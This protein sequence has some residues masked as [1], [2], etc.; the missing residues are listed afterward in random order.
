MF[1]YYFE[2]AD[3]VTHSD[4]KSNFQT[5]RVSKQVQSVVIAQAKDAFFAIKVSLAVLRHTEKV[6]VL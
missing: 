6:L 1:K 4:L 2:N 5:V 3:T